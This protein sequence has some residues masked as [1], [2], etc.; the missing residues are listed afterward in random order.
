MYIYIATVYNQSSQVQLSQVNLKC[1]S[2]VT[3][4]QEVKITILYSTLNSHLNIEL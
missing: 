4:V 1:C 3:T 2:L